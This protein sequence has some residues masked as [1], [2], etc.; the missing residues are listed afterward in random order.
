MNNNST[1][2]PLQH[3]A[4]SPNTAMALN[5][6]KYN[7]LEK[8]RQLNNPLSLGLPTSQIPN[9]LTPTVK[10]V[11]NQ[12]HSKKSVTLLEMFD[13]TDDADDGGA[14]DTALLCN[15]DVKA[16]NYH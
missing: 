12:N 15:T 5:V 11:Q 13:D 6:F 14:M 9:R 10:H 8:L 3:Y 2:Q 7:Q 16:S 1:P 4:A